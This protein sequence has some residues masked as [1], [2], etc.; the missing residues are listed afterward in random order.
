MCYASCVLEYGHSE[1]HT[2]LAGSY[3][4]KG[5]MLYVSP[6]ACFK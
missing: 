5:K 4:E 3:V 1:E 6:V 2:S